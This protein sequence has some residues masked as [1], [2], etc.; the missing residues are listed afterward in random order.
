VTLNHASRALLALVLAAAPG[1][2]ALAAT[3]PEGYR[4]AGVLAVGEDHIGFLELPQ[5]GQVLVRQGSLVNG[6]RIT[7][8]SARAMRIAFPDGTLE[9]TIE[10]TAAGPARLLARAAAGDGPVLV[11]ERQVAPTAAVRAVR[12]DALLEQI[13]GPG[14]SRAARPGGA[15][16]APPAGSRATRRGGEANVAVPALL[17]SLNLPA[18]ARIVAV[19]EQ[20]VATAREAMD[21]VEIALLSGA[22]VR[23]NLAGSP[24]AGR[25]YV[26]PAT[27]AR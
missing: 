3:S 8:F 16:A 1:L 27:G 22:V 15:A 12:T 24:Q 2:A 21:A 4:L 14:S 23:L 26:V 20:M 11:T 18:D 25:V 13:A 9:F 17:A 5:G 6:G 19:N 10:G 7:E